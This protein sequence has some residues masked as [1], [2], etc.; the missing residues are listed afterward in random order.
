MPENYVCGIVFDAA[1][2]DEAVT[3]QLR[4]FTGNSK[5]LRIHVDGW[6]WILHQ[7][8]SLSP[9]TSK[10]ALGHPSYAVRKGALTD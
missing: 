2:G 4:A 10:A 5:A 7:R 6:L 1:Q 3:L 8:N 9:D